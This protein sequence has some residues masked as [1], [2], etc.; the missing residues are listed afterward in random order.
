MERQKVCFG[1]VFRWACGAYGTGVWNRANEDLV[2]RV[3][4]FFALR[5][6]IYR[7]YKEFF[8]YEDDPSDNVSQGDEDAPQISPK[9]ATGRFYFWGF[10]VLTTKDITKWNAVA[11]MPLYL[12]LNHLA[13]HK[14][15]VLKENERIR[16]EEAQWKNM[17][18]SRG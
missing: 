3:R 1:G 16:K 13:S 14:E 5:R 9:E 18:R 2:G 17:S 12:C 4:F 7:K 15:E 11:N 10:Q 8:D 6:Q